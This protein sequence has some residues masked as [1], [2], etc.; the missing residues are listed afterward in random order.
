M[1]TATPTPKKKKVGGRGSKPGGSNPGG[2]AL[3]TRVFPKGAPHPTATPRRAPTPGSMLSSMQS[4]V[5]AVQQGATQLG[6]AIKGFW[7]PRKP[8]IGPYLP[9]KK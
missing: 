2:P 5:G 6:D 4:V 7:K 3:G 9:K 8:I 1:T